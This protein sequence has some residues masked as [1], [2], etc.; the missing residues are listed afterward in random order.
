VPPSAN[1]FER[2]I[3]RLCEYSPAPWVGKCSPTE[4]LD[5]LQSDLERLSS[6]ERRQRLAHAMVKLVSLLRMEGD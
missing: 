4:F 1:D 3:A 5:W 2:V 6:Y